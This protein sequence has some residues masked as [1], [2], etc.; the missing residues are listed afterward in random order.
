[1]VGNNKVSLE[2]IISLQWEQR[3]VLCAYLVNKV[4]LVNDWGADWGSGAAGAL[5]G[6]SCVGQ[7]FWA[8][9]GGGWSSEQLELWVV[10]ALSSSALSSWSSEWW[11][12]CV[13]GLLSS[14][15]SEWWW[16]ELWA[17]GT[18]SSWSSE[19]LELWVVA[20][21]CGRTSE[22]LEFW[23]VVAGALSSWSSEWW[24]LGA[25]APESSDPKT[26]YSMY[27]EESLSTD[28]WWIPLQYSL[29]A[30]LSSLFANV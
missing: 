30:F 7:D 2:H 9:S 18:L 6:G 8:L 11:Q 22:Q 19:Q 3:A 10:A 15:S 23:V 16:L 27:G 28:R 4:T 17:A 12:L 14:W 29:N 13:V 5:S 1:M 24:Q 25:A 21:V 26:S 20:A